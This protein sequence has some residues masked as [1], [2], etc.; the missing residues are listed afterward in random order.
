M[1]TPGTTYQLSA[2]T[3]AGIDNLRRL[4]LNT[5]LGFE[6]APEELAI[7][8]EVA[9]SAH[10]PLYD[11]DDRLNIAAT[12]S[13]FRE[14]SMAMILAYVDRVRDLPNIKKIN[15]HP[16]PRQWLYEGQSGGRQGDYGLLIEGIRRVADYAA[17]SGLDVVL[18]NNTFRW[19]GVSD[20]TP[21][22]EV[23]WSNMTI[24]FGSAP[25]EWIQIC[26]DVERP[27]VGLCLDSSHACTYAHTLSD[28]G[29]RADT[30]MKYLS[31]PDLV[32]HVHWNDNYLYDVRGR[33]DSHALLGK[34]S[35]PIEMHRAIK[36]LDATLNIE[37]F[38]SI[39]EL[40]EDL[41]F[42]AGL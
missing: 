38:Y 12:D 42:I 2:P 37:H 24:S 39:D 14:K 36:G 18:E 23:D 17:R 31:R 7:F 27:N 10:A 1:T 26:L 6:A 3:D 34:G 20:E 40:E 8:G 19:E 29:S 33:V 28:H 32:R 30:V 41:E 15:M 16:A 25:E 35:L 4:K 9:A 21:Y 22:D 5:E 11:G 13:A